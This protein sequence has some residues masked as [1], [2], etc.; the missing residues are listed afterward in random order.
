MSMCRLAVLAAML[1]FALPLPAAG[2]EPA[3]KDHPADVA[4]AD[5]GT[6]WV[7]RHFPSSLR[8]YVF[9]G[10]KPGKLGCQEECASAWPPVIAPDNAKPVGDWTTVVRGDGRKQWA[11]KGRPAYMR[12]HD[13]PDTPTGDGVDGAWHFLTP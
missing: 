5:I 3:K 12:Y 11:Y 4:L 1:L 2:A 9:D 7:Y 8:L 10:D 13:A 6:G